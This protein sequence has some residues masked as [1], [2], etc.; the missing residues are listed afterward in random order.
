[1]QPGLQILYR[2]FVHYSQYPFPA[3]TSAWVSQDACFRGIN[4]LAGLYQRAAQPGSIGPCKCGPYTGNALTYRAARSADQ[5]RR[6]FRFL[7]SPIPISTIGREE[8]IEEDSDVTTV[9]V[10]QFSYELPPENTEERSDGYFACNEKVVLQDNED[11]RDVDLLDILLETHLSTEEP[12][13]NNAPQS[14]DAVPIGPYRDSFR[15][16][17]S[18]LPRYE[19]SL[20][21]LRIPLVQ[22]RAWLELMLLSSFGVSITHLGPIFEQSRILEDVLDRF[23]L[24][25]FRKKE[26][27]LVGKHLMLWSREVWCAISF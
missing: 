20:N 25:L 22:W 10:P 13:N 9:A 12:E 14:S 11:E 21:Q 8:N 23:V 4:L 26:T 5:R 3:S 17:L 24:R 19:K 16:V 15:F 7:A 27:N 2:V 18:T 6:M 1:M